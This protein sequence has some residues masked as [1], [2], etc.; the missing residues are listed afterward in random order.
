M[1]DTEIVFDNGAVAHIFTGWHLPD[2]AHATTVQNARMI[3]S[4]GMFDIGLDTPGLHEIHPDGIFEVNPLF[5]NFEKDGTVTGY[6]ISSP[7][8][9]YQKFLANHNGKLDAE[10]K[11]QMLTPTALGFYTSLVLEG[12]EES[13]KKGTAVDGVTRGPAIDL[14]ALLVRELGQDALK[15]YGY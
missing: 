12:A 2:T 15:Q 8:R 10:V 3:C 9:I 5:K 14:K 1:A 13:L 6:G 11:K 7:G 4:D